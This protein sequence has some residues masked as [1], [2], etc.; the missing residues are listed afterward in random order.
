[1]HCFIIAEVGV[2]H[3]GD[4]EMARKLIEVAARCGAD[5]VKFQTF[6]AEKLVRPEAEKAAYQKEATGDG[7][8]FSMLQALEISRADHCKLAEHCAAS[9]VEFMSTPFDQDAADFLVEV[10]V[11]RLKVP[12]GD[13]DN[14]PLLRHLA[15]TGLPLIVSTGMSSLAEVVAAKECI[16]AE[17]SRIGL[18]EDHGDRLVVLHCTSNYPTAPKD[19]NLKAMPTI[20][21][22]LRCPVG[23]SDHTSG[24]A[25]AVAAVAMGATVIE[26]HI[27]LDKALPGP[28]HAASLDPEEFAFMVN[29]I[30]EIEVA[31]GDGI[32][33]PKPSELPVR[34]LVRRSISVARD[35]PQGTIVNGRDLVMLRPSNG[36]SPSAIDQVVGKIA[37]RDLPAGKL[38]D[39]SD[40]L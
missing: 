2:N 21:N 26:K 24:S 7:G 32:K 3:N 17:W 18:P 8:Q 35:V 36:I 37:A 1:M 4:I 10:G 13:I 34:A 28:D 12:P 22:A 15:R 38:L 11:R 9:G 19:V 29:Q 16:F 30:R 33:A 25:V 14:F 5:A 20:A 23:Y 31:L 40:L 6:S 39:W 27:T